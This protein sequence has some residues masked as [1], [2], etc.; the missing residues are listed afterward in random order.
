MRLNTTQYKE[1]EPA[2]SRV[3]LIKFALII[4]FF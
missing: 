4:L 1:E 3:D 2:V